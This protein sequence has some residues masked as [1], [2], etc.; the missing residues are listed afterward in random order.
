MT[1]KE[2]CRE[3]ILVQ[4][5]CNLSG[6]VHSFSNLLPDLRREIG[7]GDS[8]NAGTDQVNNHPVCRLFADKIASLA[9]VQGI[10]TRTMDAYSAA[11][12]FCK[13]KM[14]SEGE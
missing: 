2:M 5:A 14:E 1:M 12:K 10:T 7:G 4:D 13:D 8:L 11:Y 3:A 6:V 9:N